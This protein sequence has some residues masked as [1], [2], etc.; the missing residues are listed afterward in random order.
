MEK[1]EYV[2]HR[3]HHRKFPKKTF[4]FLIFV[5][6]IAGLW[7][8][9]FGDKGITGNV[10]SDVLLKGNETLEVNGVAFSPSNLDVPEMLL[11]GKFSK[12]EIQGGG[13]TFIEAGKQKVDLSN[14]QNSYIVLEEFVG[15]ISFNGNLIT[16][17]IGDSKSITVNG[18]PIV[19]KS[20]N[21]L[22][23]RLGAE[24]EY[25]SLD[26]SDGVYIKDLSYNTSGILEFG[27]RNN[28]F[29]L[30]NDLLHIEK[31]NGGLL[32]ENSKMDLRGFVERVEVLGK[33]KIIIENS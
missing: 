6:L 3:K 11:N 1:V 13:K 5:V 30:N 7:F 32:V 14:A 21:Y 12:V 28:I 22:K 19:P 4:F 8:T 26:V 24:M 9:A 27:E 10:V 20:G 2:N 25:E 33:T 18:L 15:K 31:F 16:G 23:T 29:R 17:I